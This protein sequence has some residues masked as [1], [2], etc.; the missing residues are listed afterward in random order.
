MGRRS[1]IPEEKWLELL[2]RYYS[3]EMTHRL[4]LEY[5]LSKSSIIQKIKRTGLKAKPKHFGNKYNFN[6]HFLD[7]IDSEEKAYFVGFLYA[8]GNNYEK[9]K[10]VKL[11]IQERDRAILERFLKILDSNHPIK[12]NSKLTPK[13]KILKNYCVFGLTNKHFSDRCSELGIVPRK[14]AILKFPLDSQIPK[15]FKPAFLR[16]YFDGDGSLSFRLDK[17]YKYCS[18]GLISS[19][20]FCAS[21]KEFVESIAGKTCG[22]LIKNKRSKG[23][24]NYTVGGI[25]QIENFLNLIYKGS[26]IHLDRKYQKYISFL[27]L[28][29]QFK[30]QGFAKSKYFGVTI[31]GSKVLANVIINGHKKYLGTFSNEESAARCYDVYCRKNNHN[32]CDLNFPQ[33]SLEISTSIAEAGRLIQMRS[34][35]IEKIRKANSRTFEERY[36]AEKAAEI[37]LARA[38]KRKGI[39]K[40]P[41]IPV[42]ADGVSYPSMTAAAMAL[43]ISV[44]TVKKRFV[45]KQATETEK[46]QPNS[47]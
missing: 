15:E 24:G 42:V 25:D 37:K 9:T 33:D 38:G 22:Y 45:V 14:S 34:D 18:A 10:T 47:V 17:D 35:T 21:T 13:T 12:T 31:S 44:A 4:A 29:N 23:M 6:T 27:S 3:G 26:T 20:E 46:I 36:G 5:G 28:K 30:R 39:K 11:E 32:T 41:S 1:K 7:E 8:D 19:K 43:K 16:G 40:A 2:N